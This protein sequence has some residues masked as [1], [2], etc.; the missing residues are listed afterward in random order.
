MPERDVK[1]STGGQMPPMPRELPNPP[2]FYQKDAGGA[3][4]INSCPHKESD[5]KDLLRGSSLMANR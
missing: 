5:F 1:P 2:Y 4:S 3:S